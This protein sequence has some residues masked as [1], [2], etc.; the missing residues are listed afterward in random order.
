MPASPFPDP[1][2]YDALFETS[3]APDP[4][5]LADDVAVERAFTRAAKPYLSTPWSWF[6]W[7]LILPAAALATPTAIILGGP[8][9]VA[10][11]WT[12]AIVV[13]G[14]VEGTFLFRNR[15]RT[16]RSRWSAWAMRLQGN[17]SLVAVALSAVFLWIDA[18]ELLP[19]LWLLLLGH[20]FF[21]LG[22]LAF[23]PMRT[24]GVIYQLGG[25]AALVPGGFPLTALALATALGNLWIGFGVWR[26][27]RRRSE[28]QPRGSSS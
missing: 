16:R 24:A 17:L 11:L 7:A 3:S 25:A 12:V 13:G 20:S 2:E 10:I 8:L 4:S 22:G 9:A 27:L 23:S 21:A 28:I 6:A 18:S 1:S 5:V 26:D 19:A 15:S 14:T